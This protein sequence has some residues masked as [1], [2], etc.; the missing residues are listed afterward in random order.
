MAVLSHFDVH[1]Q[2]K[3]SSFLTHYR[4]KLMTS[5]YSFFS[6]MFRFWVAGKVTFHMQPKPIDY[7]TKLLLFCHNVIIYINSS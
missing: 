5:S 4:I 1:I 6:L 2:S 7:E 3:T